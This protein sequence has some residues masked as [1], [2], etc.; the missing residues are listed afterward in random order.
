MAE[1]KR[2]GVLSVAKIAAAIMLVVGLIAGIIVALF[3]AFLTAASPM[4]GIPWASTG[5]MTMGGIFAIVVITI[6]YAI[7]G[8][9]WGAICAFLYNVAAG[10]FGGIELEL[11]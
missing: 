1:L 8:F 10:W 4:L 6:M 3:G 11:E 5:A 2:V 7:F 9:I